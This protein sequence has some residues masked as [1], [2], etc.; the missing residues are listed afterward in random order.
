MA[1]GAGALQSAVMLGNSRPFLEECA[2]IVR[3]AALLVVLALAGCSP[4]EKRVVLD[5]AQS[6]E[7]VAGIGDVM[8]RADVKEDLPNLWGR[9]D[10]YGRTRDRGFSEL[11]Y[12]GLV[13]EKAAF[14][15]RDVD[16]MT[17]ETT[18]SRS[19]F[20]TTVVNIQP[21]GQGFVAY[22][23]STRAPGATMQPLPPD[24]I[25]FT[26]DL[27]L[28]KILTIRGQTIDIID[29][30]PGLIKYIIR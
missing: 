7:L 10:L 26:L 30:A 17:N 3:V 28:T 29:A 1:L 23:V 5:Q 22:G 15:R 14:R 25:E 6:V 20:G 16:I 4:V 18:M 8:L 2:P 27:R 13:G 12:M 21:A 19:G 24:T 9:A 11:R